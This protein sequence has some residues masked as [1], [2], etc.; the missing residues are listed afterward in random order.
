MT[1][2]ISIYYCYLCSEGD[3]KQ[4]H[5]VFFYNGKKR[6]VCETCFNTNDIR[7]KNCLKCNREFVSF[8]KKFLCKECTEV[9]KG[10]MVD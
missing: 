5:F 7:F 2:K 3:R 8:N 4:P 6:G 1:K 9:N 10:I